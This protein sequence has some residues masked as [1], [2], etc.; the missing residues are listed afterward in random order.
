MGGHGNL[1][2]KVISESRRKMGGSPGTIWGKKQDEK[3]LRGV[4]V[5]GG[6]K[7]AGVAGMWGW[8]AVGTEV[9]EGRETSWEDL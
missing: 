5:Q 1:T 9:Q 8:R 2:D 3:R 4:T 6:S 7:G